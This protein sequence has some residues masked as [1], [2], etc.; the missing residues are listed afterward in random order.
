MY[1]SVITA[2]ELNQYSDTNLIII[3]CRFQ[4]NDT[5]AGRKA[6]DVSH[7]TGA[8]YSHLDKDCSGTITATS[9]RHPLP[10]IHTFLQTISKWGIQKDSQVIVYD[11]G[12]GGIAA[13]LWWMLK[14]IGLDSVAVLNGGFSYWQSIGYPLTQ[15]VPSY[16]TGTTNL[17]ANGWSF[18]SMEQMKEFINNSDYLIIDARAPERYAGETEPIDPIAGHIPSAINRFHGLNFDTN[19]CIK[20]KEELEI[21]FSS[22]IGQYPIENVIVYCGSGVTSCAHLFPLEYINKKGAKLYAGSWSE[23]IKYPENPIITK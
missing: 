17:T 22:L 18:V 14:N 5:E 9:S 2:E 13:R 6:Y 8:Y 23:W 20:S 3:D 4:L 16:Q 19:D 1:T 15:E 11:A 21:E 7:L 10:D 12:A